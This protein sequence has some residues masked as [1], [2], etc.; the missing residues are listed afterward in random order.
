[1]N[2][3]GAKNMHKID[4]TEAENCLA[5]LVKEAANGEKV[6]ITQEDGSAFQLVP[7][8]NAPDSSEFD[9]GKLFNPEGLWDQMDPITA[10]DIAE[11]RKNYLVKFSSIEETTTWLRRSSRKQKR[12]LP[13]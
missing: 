13:I 11:A 4:L 9:Q 3:N 10:R 6:V 8:A 5:A 2:T 12:A 1:M 7:M